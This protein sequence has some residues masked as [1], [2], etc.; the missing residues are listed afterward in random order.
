MTRR[1]K[2]EDNR[3]RKKVQLLKVGDG[4]EWYD[5]APPDDELKRRQDYIRRNGL[6]A[7]V[8]VWNSYPYYGLEIIPLEQMPLDKPPW[9]GNL[10]ILH[11]ELMVSIPELI[12]Q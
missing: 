12:I 3:T 7:N 1:F 9:V 8:V 11:L 5:R 2:M 4:R 10:G 6:L